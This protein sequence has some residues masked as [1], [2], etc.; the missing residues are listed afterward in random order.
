R[1]FRG[2]P[3]GRGTG[4]ARNNN[5]GAGTWARCGE[6]APEYFQR[7][8][9]SR[10]LIGAQGGEGRNIRSARDSDCCRAR[11]TGVFRTGGGNGDQVG[12][13]RRWRSNVKPG[14]IDGPARPLNAASRTRNGPRH[15]LIV[16][17]RYRR[18]EQLLAPAGYRGASRQYA[19]G[20]TQQDSYASRFVFGVV[21]V[22]GSRHGDRVGGWQARG[23]EIIDAAR[24]T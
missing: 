22:T 11:L 2:R 24:I 15:L 21:S 4:R 12:R 19:Y 8:A 13:R 20:D 18:R 6:V 14:G 1:A 17:A 9:A 23:R 3:A 16:R 10:P 7:E 5:C